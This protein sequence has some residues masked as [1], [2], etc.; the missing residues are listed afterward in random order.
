M[1]FNKWE[2]F[3]FLRRI[4]HILS[5]MQNLLIVKTSVKCVRSYYP[6]PKE[7]MNLQI[8]NSVVT[9]CVYQPVYAQFK[10]AKAIPTEWPRR[11]SALGGAWQLLRPGPGNPGGRDD[12]LITSL[13]PSFLGAAR[14]SR[15][16]TLPKNKPR[17][18]KEWPLPRGDKACGPR[19]G[20]GRAGG[21]FP[22]VPPA[23]LSH[24]GATS[25]RS[26]G[27]F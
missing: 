12:G 18:K 3:F 9:Q 2:N 8:C 6:Y 24:P 5:I 27:R 26:A 11:E 16:R 10:T 4:I 21:R 14:M 19:G 23:A 15:I 7:G 25:S 17:R 13:Q 20:P 22:G 1:Y